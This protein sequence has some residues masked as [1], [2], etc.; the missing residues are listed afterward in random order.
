MKG[1]C[2]Q[3]EVS[4]SSRYGNS[5][6]SIQFYS[7]IVANAAPNSII[8]FL[9]G[10]GRSVFQDGPRLLL[11]IFLC[12][13]SLWAFMHFIVM[14]TQTSST[15]QVTLSFA[16]AFDQLARVSFEQ[17]LLWASFHGPKLT[18]TTFLP[19]G[20]IILRFILGGVFVGLQRPQLQPVCLSYTLLLPLGITV[21]VVDT[22]LLL[23]FLIKLNWS[24]SSE[25]SLTKDQGITRD[26][27]LIL[28][29]SAFGVWTALS[30]PMILGIRSFHFTLRTVLPAVGLLVLIGVVMLCRNYLVLE[31]DQGPIFT[32]DGSPPR[33]HRT[34][35]FVTANDSGTREAI[36]PAHFGVPSS[37][38]F[39]GKRGTVTV[40]S[41]HKPN[42][43][44]DKQLPT[45]SQPLPGR[46]SVGIGGL[47]VAGQ[48]F[49]PMRSE[50]QWNS[51]RG[52]D[53]GPSNYRSAPGSTR[54]E[55]SGLLISNPILDENSDKNPLN[56]IATVDL[57][58][59]ARRDKEQRR[60]RH[61][62]PLKSHSV[63][64]DRT[65]Q[66]PLSAPED[67]IRQSHI[68][69][70]ARAGDT[71][72]TADVPSLKLEPIKESSS[73]ASSTSAQPSPGIEEMRRRSPRHPVQSSF[74][75]MLFPPPPPLKTPR[76]VS[77][78]MTLPQKRGQIKPDTWD[79]LAVP[80]P[81]TTGDS[82]VLTSPSSPSRGR[83]ATSPVARS[84][85]V[86]TLSSRPNSAGLHSRSQSVSSRKSRSRDVIFTDPRTPPPIP[87]K[88]SIIRTEAQAEIENEV[89]RSHPPS[90][91]TVPSIITLEKSAMNKPLPA[92]PT[93][94]TT[95]GTLS[96]MR[97][98]RLSL[99][100]STSTTKPAN[101]PSN[102]VATKTLTSPPRA[103]TASKPRPQD[104]HSKVQEQTIMLLKEIE[105]SKPID[106]NDIVEQYLG[107]KPPSSPST[108]ILDS[109]LNRPRPIPRTPETGRMFQFFRN[110]PQARDHR[111]SLSCS[112]VR[113]DKSF[114]HDASVLQADL[115]MVPPIQKLE[116]TQSMTVEEKMTMLLPRAQSNGS[117]SSRTT[118]PRSTSLPGIVSPAYDM[119]KLVQLRK[120]E[121]D[122][123]RRSNRS[124]ATTVR[125]LSL[126]TL[127]E[128]PITSYHASELP[129]NANQYSIEESTQTFT[130]AED[131]QRSLRDVKRQ[132][133]P[134]LPASDLETPSTMTDSPRS[135]EGT[136]TIRGSIA[137]V[138][139]TIVPA[140]AGDE[141]HS[142]A[143]DGEVV[144]LNASNGYPRVIEESSEESCESGSIA[145]LEFDQSPRSVQIEAADIW[146][147]RVGEECPTF[148][149]RKGVP[150][151]RKAPPPMPLPLGQPG[152]GRI[153]VAA[154]PSPLES[155]SH[156]LEL[157][158]AQL[159][160]LEESDRRSVVTE[161]QRVTLLANLEMEMGMQ[162][163]QWQLLRRNTIRDSLST[164]T[165]S[166]CKDNGIDS[167]GLP[168][169][170]RLERNS[171][172]SMLAEN[173]S[174]RHLLESSRNIESL[175]RRS[176]LSNAGSRMSFLTVA[177]SSSQLGSPTPPDTD[178]SDSEGHVDIPLSLDQRIASKQVVPSLWKASVSSPV[179]IM[180]CPK[181]WS[182]TLQ[183][184]SDPLFDLYISPD[185]PQTHSSSARKSEP[186]VI[187]TSQLWRPSPFGSTRKST[188]GLWTS[189][190]AHA[191]ESQ[192]KGKP[193]PLSRKPS[194][195]SKR[196]TALPDIPESPLP[197][198]DKRGGLGIFQFPWGET[199]DMATIAA[200]TFPGSAMPGTIT[201]GHSLAGSFFG[202]FQQ[203][204]HHGLGVRAD[205]YFEDMDEEENAG[206]NFSDF[207]DEDDDDFDE[208]TLWEIASLL[209]SSQVP[210]RES[211][212][213]GEWMSGN[214]LDPFSPQASPATQHE[215]IVPL[216][217]DISP[218]PRAVAKPAPRL[219]ENKTRLYKRIGGFG[220]P[221]PHS[222]AWTEYTSSTRHG[223]HPAKRREVDNPA[224]VAGSMWS[225]TVTKRQYTHDGHRLWTSE[226]M[227]ESSARSASIPHAGTDT[228]GEK[229]LVPRLWT[230]SLTA[231]EKARSSDESSDLWNRSHG[232]RPDKFESVANNV[233][234]VRRLETSLIARV[235]SVSLWS[236]PQAD[237][238]KVFRSWLH[239]GVNNT[240]ET[241][242]RTGHRLRRVPATDSDW[243]SALAQAIDASSG[244]KAA[245]TAPNTSQSL[246]PLPSLWSE[247]HNHG[248]Q[249]SSADHP[250]YPPHLWTPD[251]GETRTEVNSSKLPPLSPLPPRKRTNT[252]GNEEAAGGFPEFLD[253]G[254]WS[255]VEAASRLSR[256]GKQT[257]WI[258]RRVW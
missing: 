174:S 188:A 214:G 38:D 5:Y 177:H 22:T 165:P 87:E 179:V 46:S 258:A 133:S 47:P 12:A 28:S 162:E 101:R 2:H 232:P 70:E 186:P 189:P 210:S 163:S 127:S 256:M 243:A 16:S 255:R 221:Q 132:S 72:G 25:G 107:K 131:S 125:T 139:R 23:L 199:S 99:F 191:R 124:S 73:V 115:P 146:H 53:A 10:H 239:V 66:L 48:L 21:L 195:K 149:D 141:A 226:K 27:K 111:R 112:S 92:Q 31:I 203:D 110:T 222:A 60:A 56:K 82:P 182:P 196:I 160:K 50:N 35:A 208:S 61:P 242:S 252:V 30:S 37:Q 102:K 76:T 197:L 215:E 237:S 89:P 65:S 180:S 140:V 227:T 45:I 83:P 32:P 54:H 57:E 3:E 126:F 58:T 207:D 156:A 213:P 118:R 185:T 59:A 231:T 249:Q 240:D 24:R 253:Q 241:V 218:A 148:S 129:A 170:P 190:S 228:V 229:A 106:V 88:C 224:S 81:L 41:A 96:P 257:D 212:L 247:S 11:V 113:V 117:N 103:N 204:Q 202:G 121:V 166:P 183:R 169:I 52:Q 85:G 205:S 176:G 6:L 161:Q 40:I 94:P 154:E 86:M 192:Q 201:S 135:F 238:A 104:D 34:A 236:N 90:Y 69:V 158:N 67:R 159:K 97:N 36:P 167:L 1:D 234:R 230:T 193:R 168:S 171:L 244:H 39:D 17:F 128:Q 18:L 130:Y 138:A 200:P 136:M 152:K 198:P 150:K 20:I 75:P 217:L 134:V 120:Q 109:V 123:D 105:Y 172:R 62:Q 216:V 55:E 114:L 157:I 143:S 26:K 44:L 164:V 206:D 119:G 95:A 68:N 29:T 175:N 178:E 254:L 219:W 19:Q 51:G 248:H 194:R 63:L 233:P 74:E 153:I 80:E 151:P 78:S 173:R 84:I 71:S 144:Q 100:P 4:S 8:L 79:L 122:D 181:L 15:C 245:T 225:K 91:R 42:S 108:V 137:S 98:D 246:T 33:T 116:Q 211:L 49:P 13:A 43:S 155:P 142:P 145:S 187:E 147:R 9:K 223:L 14:T 209:Q 220:L 250:H 93:R 184:A 7:G 251:W 64:F 235:S 77:T